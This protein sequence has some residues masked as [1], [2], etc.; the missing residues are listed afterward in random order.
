MYHNLSSVTL[1]NLPIALTRLDNINWGIVNRDNYF[2]SIADQITFTDFTDLYDGREV[3]LPINSEIARDHYNYMRFHYEN[4]VGVDKDYY[5]FVEDWLY[6]S[7]EVCTPVQLMDTWTTFYNVL[8]NNQTYFASRLSCKAEKYH[9]VDGISAPKYK[10]TPINYDDK[11]YYAVLLNKSKKYPN[12]RNTG[13]FTLLVYSIFIIYG[14][15]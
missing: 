12:A 5:F 11:S 13:T 6:I 14:F 8:N 10:Y 2:K 9:K 1:Y 7:Q 15:L 3:L 4:E